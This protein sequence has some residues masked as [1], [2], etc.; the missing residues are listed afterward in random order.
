MVWSL[1]PTFA[2]VTAPLK[3]APITLAWDSANDPSVQR[4]HGIYYGPT[5]QPTTNYVNAGTNLSV[6]LFDLLANT[7][8]WFYAVSYDAAGNESV[9]SNQLWLHRP[10][11][12]AGVDCAAG[13]R[14]FP[15]CLARGA[16]I[17]LPG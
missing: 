2:A 14:R 4:L 16:R 7:G 6:T 13:H 12:L 9:P 17:G 8:Y 10:G 1:A 3:S 15:P 5:N 11:L